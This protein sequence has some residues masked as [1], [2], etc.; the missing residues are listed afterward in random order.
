[1]VEKNIIIKYETIQDLRDFIIY[2]EPTIDY[3]KLYSCTEEELKDYCII[4]GYIE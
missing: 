3:N 1:M 4:K 2:L